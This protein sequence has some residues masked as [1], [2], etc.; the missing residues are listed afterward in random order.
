MS[1]NHS[2]E[3]ALDLVIAGG[4]MA[5]S[6][7]AYVLLC[8]NPG[9][10]L[11]IVEQ[12]SELGKDEQ[13]SKASFDSRSIALAHGS[14]EL[15]QQWGLWQELQ[16]SGCAIKHI[17]ISDRGHF[18]KTYLNAADYQLSALGQVIEV[19]AIGEVL[20]QKLKAF[21]A[22]GRLS[23]FYSDA[24]DALN[25]TAELQHIS[26]KSGAQLQS[27]LLVIAEGGLSPS[28]TL[29]GFELKSDDYQQH[30][31]IANIGVA[32]SHQHKAFERFTPTGPLA[33]LPLTRQR[34]SLVWTLTPE[35]AAQHVQQTDAEFLAAL[36]QAAGHRAGVFKTVGQRV[37]YP[38][39]LKRATEASRH[40]TVLVGNSLHNLHPIAG[41]GFNL[42][43]RD[44]YS[45][46]LLLQK[47]QTDAGCYALTTAYQQARLP[48]MQ[49]VILYTDS[50]VRLFSNRSR[51]M[52]L[53]RN[54]GLLALNLCPELK[55]V[56]AN[57]AMGLNSI[58][59]LKALLTR[60]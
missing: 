53:G 24:I 20:W 58:R 30:A 1:D 60:A 57:Q 52:A 10:K 40:R 59:Q 47:H 38:L 34:Y 2:A 37:V 48:D 33:L 5:G 23:W 51:L 54:T 19:E 9:L 7:L 46:T 22:Q 41:Q 36:Q 27:K 49:Q 25:P 50:L 15:L 55:Q 32:D 21:T 13:P 12:S 14:V 42:A 45:L 11:A 44:I 18:G 16:P 29:A 43:I 17:H 26:L 35:Q 56:V 4:G 8:Q 3:Q 6:L 28:R 31:L 39:S